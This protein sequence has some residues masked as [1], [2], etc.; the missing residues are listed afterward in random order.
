MPIVP[1]HQPTPVIPGVKGGQYVMPVL[2][3]EGTVAGISCPYRSWDAL[4]LPM[5]DLATYGEIRGRALVLWGPMRFGS[6][7]WR[8]KPEFRSVRR[9]PY[10]PRGD[11]PP[12]APLRTL[13]SKNPTRLEGPK[14]TAHEYLSFPGSRGLQR[15]QWHPNEFTASRSGLGPRCRYPL[16][17]YGLWGERWPGQPVGPTSRPTVPGPF[18]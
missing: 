10:G 7:H 4:E 1:H 12:P 3:R 8:T 15:L 16:Q 9:V 13:L 2:R 18:A 17:P 11:P 14:P 5:F 6:A